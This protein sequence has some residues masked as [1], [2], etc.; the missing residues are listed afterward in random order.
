MLILSSAGKNQFRVEVG[1]DKSSNIKVRRRCWYLI[2][3]F[4]GSDNLNKDEFWS[5]S[6]SNNR[7]IKNVVSRFKIRMKSPW[8]YLIFSRLDNFLLV[9]NFLV[10]MIISQ[11]WIILGKRD[12]KSGKTNWNKVI[13]RQT[14]IEW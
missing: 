13:N 1:S 3:G 9:L 10:T 2:P 8:L 7:N 6:V 11:H 5:K 12:L 14:K 4:F